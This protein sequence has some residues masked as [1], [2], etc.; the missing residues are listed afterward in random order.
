MSLRAL[1]AEVFRRH[2]VKV[3][4]EAIRRALTNALFVPKAARDSVWVRTIKKRLPPARAGRVDHF[5][6]KSTT[7]TSAC[8]SATLT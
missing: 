6:S 7:N 8:R 4:H 5:S 1:S 2:G 3:S